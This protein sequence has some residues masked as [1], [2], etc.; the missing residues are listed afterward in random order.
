MEGLYA[1]IIMFIMRL[2]QKLHI[3]AYIDYVLLCKMYS[4]SLALFM[5]DVPAPL[6]LD[7]GII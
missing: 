3:T 2:K 6:S 1:F 7:Y 5:K 4:F